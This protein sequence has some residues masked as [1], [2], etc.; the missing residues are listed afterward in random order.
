VHWNNHSD[1]TVYFYPRYSVEDDD[2]PSSGKSGEWFT[3]GEVI[4][5]AEGVYIHEVSLPDG[6]IMLFNSN[7]NT[8]Q[9]KKI[10]LDRI[11]MQ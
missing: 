7:V 5:P 11:T 10:S 1:E 3:Q 8:S 9:K 6:E 4:I 2:R